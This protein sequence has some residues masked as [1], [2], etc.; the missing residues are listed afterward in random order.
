MTKS[1]A[2]KAAPKALR[3]SSKKKDAELSIGMTTE[4]ALDVG[5]GDPALDALMAELNGVGLPTGDDEVVLPAEPE[6]ELAIESAA[7]VTVADDDVLS[8]AVSGAEMLEAYDKEAAAADLPADAIEPKAAEPAPVKEKKARAPKAPKEPKEPKAPR[9]FY[10]LDKLRR[11]T[12]RGV[13][14][15]MLKSEESLTGDELAAAQQRTLDVVA[16]ANQKVKNRTSNILEYVTGKTNTLNNLIRVCFNLVE[17]DGVLV[18]GEKGNMWSTLSTC[19]DPGTIRSGGNNSV[20]ALRDLQILVKTEKGY[21]K[22]SDSALY[23][24]I[25]ARLHAAEAPAG[26]DEVVDEPAAV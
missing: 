8:A 11:L 1:V 26:S 7:P 19:Y 15:V 23:E 21:V 16:K 24:R 18:T 13:A 20:A 14:A 4:V 22:N 2:A 12:D 25:A 17:K 9:V 10:G 6:N 3:K 5:T